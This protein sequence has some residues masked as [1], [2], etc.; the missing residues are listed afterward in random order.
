MILV[1][2]IP[3]A[4]QA[5]IAEEFHAE[6]GY[7]EPKETAAWLRTKGYP[8]EV[9]PSMVGGSPVFLFPSE[10]DYAVFLLRWA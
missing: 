3:T 1:T 10:E 5:R 6:H 4:A 8:I 2:E 9:R 7:L